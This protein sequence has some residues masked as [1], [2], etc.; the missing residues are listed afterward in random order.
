MQDEA[1][2]VERLF[3]M[4]PPMIEG[5][6]AMKFLEMNGLNCRKKALLTGADMEISVESQSSNFAYS[7]NDDA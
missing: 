3:A 4:K 1:G 6:L 5:S 2:C 7:T